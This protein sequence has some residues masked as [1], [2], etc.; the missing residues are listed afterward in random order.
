MNMIEEKPSVL[1]YIHDQPRALMATYNNRS[2]FLNPFKKIFEN[3][4]I[5][6]ISLSSPKVGLKITV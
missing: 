1:G 4:K 2:E 3:K 6:K 5:K